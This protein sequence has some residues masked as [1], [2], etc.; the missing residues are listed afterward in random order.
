M[1]AMDYLQRFRNIVGVSFSPNS[2]YRSESHNRK[3][4]G[5]KKSQH[6]FGKAFDIPIKPGMSRQ[7]IK[8]VA[9]MVGFRGIGDYNNFVHID[10]GPER[11]WDYRK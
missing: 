1:V 8:E 3:V 2:A 5:A 10:T 11:Y 6:R 7:T 4:G 9:K